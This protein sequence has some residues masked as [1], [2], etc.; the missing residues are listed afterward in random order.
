MVFDGMGDIGRTPLM[1]AKKPNID[2]LSKQGS[3]G[4]YKIK[5]SKA[6]ESDMG[7]LSLLSN[8]YDYPGRG[9]LEALG[10]GMKPGKGDI[11][12]RGDFATLDENRI[13]IDRRAGR[14]ETGLKN[15]CKK[16]DRMVIDGVRFTV[17]KSAGHRVV[18]MLHGNGLSRDITSND[19]K[20]AGVK[21]N[22]IKATARKGKFTAAVVN[23]FLK[24]IEKD[25]A[26]MPV[27][28]KRKFP[29]NA[30]LIRSP[31]EAK[32]VRSFNKEFNVKACCIAGIP[33][34]KGVAR[35]LGM[36]IINVR[37]ATGDAKT[38]LAGKFSA[39]GRS[40]KKYNF[41]FFHVNATDFFAHDARQKEKT[42]YIEKIDRHLG[43]FLK[44]I[45]SKDT[46]IV[47]TCDHRTASSPSYKKYRH[48]NLP[49]PFM[50]SGP[51]IKPMGMD[52]N[53]NS[54]GKGI[55]PQQNHFIQFMMK[56]RI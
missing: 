21:M 49:V 43:K 42:K 20:L 45:D 51:G 27:N 12:I 29:A 24:R 11:C 3:L 30:I 48:L 5:Y 17:K 55:K 10:I 25:L 31:S 37:G 44:H 41:I 39:L 52:F 34:A 56:R 6:V 32:P 4:L 16:L 40:H 7:Y 35:F 50:I 13:I 19:P 33:I 2:A 22:L 54:C 23:K 36:D 8:Y 47:I 28:K 38:N 15:I 53:E 18:L 26:V 46:R 1:M 9:Y 14:D